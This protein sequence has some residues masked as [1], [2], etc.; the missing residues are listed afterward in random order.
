MVSGICFMSW[1]L[2]WSVASGHIGLG[3]YKRIVPS[4]SLNSEPKMKTTPASIILIVEVSLEEVGVRVSTLLPF[5]TNTQIVQR[6]EK[7]AE[8]TAASTLCTT[9]PHTE[10]VQSMSLCIPPG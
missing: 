7:N 4:Y 8:L 10:K 2:V 5:R 6:T 1:D 3:I 9:S